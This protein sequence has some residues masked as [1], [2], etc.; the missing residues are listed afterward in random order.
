[1]SGPG[2]GRRWGRR[3]LSGWALRLHVAL[4]VV[5]PGCAAAFWIEL[6]RA[7]AGNSLSWAYTLEWPL[8]GGFSGYLWWRLWHENDPE[9]P[10]RRTDRE[11]GAGDSAGARAG[12]VTAAAAGAGTGRSGIPA[13]DPELL[14]WN[15]YLARLHALDP[16]GGPPEE[17]PRA[18]GR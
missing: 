11:A 4:L 13:D 16:P 12:T 3:W 6:A 5:L 1:M 17:Q 8:I 10:P 9:A 14:A 18:A 15:E 2:P 7:R